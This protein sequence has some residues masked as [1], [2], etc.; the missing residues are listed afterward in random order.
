MGK[1]GKPSSL[2]LMVSFYVDNVLP[3]GFGGKIKFPQTHNNVR[4]LQV[5]LYKL[6]KLKNQF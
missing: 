6:Y 3:K 4:V 5:L 2:I 1:L